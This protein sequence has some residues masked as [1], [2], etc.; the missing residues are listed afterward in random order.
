[1]KKTE[2]STLIENVR[3]LIAGIFIGW[4]NA[5][6]GVSGG[7][8][9][10]ITGVFERLIEV[11]N[12]IVNFQLKKKDTMFLIL[13]VL[14]LLIG[15]V[16]GSKI[17]MWG[18][19]NYPLYTYSFFFGLVLFSLLNIKE[20]ITYFRPLEFLLGIFIVV[21]PYLVTKN[22]SA[23]VNTILNN[24]SA[25]YVNYVFLFFAGIIA[26]SSMV[27]PGLSGSLMLMILG[28]YEQ[29]ISIVAKM[30]NIKNIAISD[31]GFLTVLGIGVLFGI[32]MIA[33][34]LKIW[35]EKAKLSIMNFILGLVAGSLYPIT[36]AFHG[37]GNTIGM[38]I[39]I[40]IGSTVVYFLGKIK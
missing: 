27:L 34:I 30:T 3:A 22:L 32:G 15:L 19:K 31:I 23:N 33:K 6:P 26:G 21:F 5:I 11:V 17:L 28:F 12:D 2:N 40:F 29:A 8:L 39:W 18:F 24:S 35:F 14:G 4:A 1:M 10:V 13:I 9:A 38:L 37:Q 25:E 7:T 16:T 36:P 20:D